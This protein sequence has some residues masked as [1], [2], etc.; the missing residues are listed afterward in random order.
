TWAKLPQDVF[1][2]VASA[3]FIVFIV[4]LI[5]MIGVAIILSNKFSNKF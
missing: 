3:G 1:Q 4:I 2:N 5:F